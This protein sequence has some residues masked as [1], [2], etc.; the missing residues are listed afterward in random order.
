MR[1]FIF[2]L[3]L[4][5]TNFSYAAEVCVKPDVCYNAPVMK[6]RKELKKGLMFVQSMPKNEGMLFDFHGRSNVAM[7][8][9]NTYISLDMLFIDCS[10]K[11]SDV[12]ENAKP[13]SLDLIKPKGEVCYVLEVNAGE[14]KAHDIKIGDAIEIKQ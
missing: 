6:T 9:K 10:L 7:W 14:I 8:M 1:Y 13:L 11:I 2:L 4:F 12:F 5:A 3:M